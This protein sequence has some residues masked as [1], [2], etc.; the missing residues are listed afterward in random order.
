MTRP[1]ALAALQVVIV[2][3]GVSFSCCRVCRNPE[4][5][6]GPYT[7]ML[8]IDVGGPGTDCCYSLVLLLWN[9]VGRNLER[10]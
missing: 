2:N 9:A 4:L 5:E 7:D 3:Q 6:G 8:G 1:L 10:H